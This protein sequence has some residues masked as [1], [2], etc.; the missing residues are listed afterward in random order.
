MTDTALFASRVGYTT[1]RPVVP[2][3]HVT[4]VVLVGEDSRQ[5][6]S[7]ARQLAVTWVHLGHRAE[8]VTSIDLV[9]AEI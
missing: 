5:G 3:E 4:H 9:H 2:D 1:P 6:L 8:M 7:D